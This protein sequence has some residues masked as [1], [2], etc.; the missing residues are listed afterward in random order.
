M[1]DGTFEAEPDWAA[2][3][4]AETPVVF[5]AMPHFELARQLQ[6]LEAVWERHDLKDRLTLIDLSGDFRLDSAA[7]FERAYGK[8]HTY[9]QALGSFIYGLPEWQKDKIKGAKR[10]ASPGCFA[11]TIQLALLPL[12]G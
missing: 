2:F 4:K 1:V 7:E 9:P 8:P 3:A 5:S 12:A 11:T 10:I 6:E